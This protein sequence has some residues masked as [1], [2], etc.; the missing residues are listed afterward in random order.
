MHDPDN[1]K[2]P[3]IQM[4]FVCALHVLRQI[5]I[6]IVEYSLIDPVNCPIVAN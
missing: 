5:K 4:F 3:I 1:K 6:P 2:D